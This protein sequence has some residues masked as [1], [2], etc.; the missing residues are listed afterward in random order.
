MNARLTRRVFFALFPDDPVRAALVR[1]AARLVPRYAGRA[2]R[3][4]TLHLT[5]LFLGEVPVQTIPEICSWGDAVACAAFDLS[6]DAHASFRDNKVAWLGC[7]EPPPALMELERQL[8]APLLRA[9]YRNTGEFTPHLTFARD[10]RYLLPAGPVASPVHWHI[11]RF[12]LI[13][14]EL[15]KGPR[16]TVLKSWPLLAA[17]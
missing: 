11:D 8:S 14:S 4:E 12:V 16:Y 13:D 6:I 5:L 10:C 2:M 7:T 3:A 1:E 9:A 15:D 17:T